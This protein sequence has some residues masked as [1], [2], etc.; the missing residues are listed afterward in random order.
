MKHIKLKL[1]GGNPKILCSFCSVVIRT[2]TQQEAIYDTLFP[3]EYCD[4]C[5]EKL[6]HYN[7]TESF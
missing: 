6:I 2:A 1:N 7:K 3:R 4:K 5:L